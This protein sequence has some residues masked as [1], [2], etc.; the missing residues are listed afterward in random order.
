MPLWAYPP[1]LVVGTDCYHFWCKVT[2]QGG[3][4]LLC[5]LWFPR[6]K[7]IESLQHLFAC[8]VR[9]PAAIHSSGE[10]RCLL[11]MAFRASPP[12]LAVGLGCDL[13]RRECIVFFGIPLRHKL[14][15]AAGQIV[16]PRQ[17]LSSCTVWTATTGGP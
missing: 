14:R 5:Q 4:P 8:A 16:K 15:K 1:H 7:V 13:L 11:H 3:M 9:A 10:H 12:H 2:V 6:G 17:H